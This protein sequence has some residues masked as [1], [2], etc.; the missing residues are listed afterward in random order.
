M[1]GVFKTFAA[2]VGDGLQVGAQVFEARK[3]VKRSSANGA[4]Q[5]AFSLTAGVYIPD[6]QLVFEQPFAT[7]FIAAR[8][9][10]TLARAQYG[11]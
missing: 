7:I 8:A 3:I 1:F 9:Y 6:T 4:V 10:I 5:T 2:V 11:T